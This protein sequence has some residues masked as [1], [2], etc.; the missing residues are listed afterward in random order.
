[1]KVVTKRREHVKDD[2]DE[3][4]T[5]SR[6]HPYSIRKTRTRDTRGAIMQTRGWSWHA[7]HTRNCRFFK[8]DRG[9]R[10]SI[11][12]LLDHS[13]SGQYNAPQPLSIWGNNSCTFNKY[14]W[15]RTDIP[16]LGNHPQNSQYSSPQPP[17]HIIGGNN[18]CT[19]NTSSCGRGN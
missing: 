8:G 2:E 11:P 6:R 5:V 7:S 12:C 15:G 1:M 17:A 9:G 16:Y 4:D 14:S 3:N 13:H 10:A 18:C 19:F